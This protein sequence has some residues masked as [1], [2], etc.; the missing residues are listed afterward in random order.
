MERIRAGFCVV[1]NPFNPKQVSRVSLVPDDVDAIVF[2]TRNLRPLIPHLRELD[3][4]GY[5][6][7]FLYTITGYPRVL[8]PNTPDTSKAVATF[9]EL[10]G[11]VGRERVIWRYDPILISNLTPVSY[12]MENFGGLV[13]ELRTS[14]ERVIVSLVD[15]Y[16][17]SRKRLASIGA[18]P[19]EIGPENLEFGKLFESMASQAHA[20]GLEITSC[21]E[22]IDL[23]PYG[24]HPGK[25]IDSAHIRRVLGIDVSHEKDKNQRKTC[26][27]VKSKD[28]G[29]Y[30]TCTH[31][32]VYCYANTN[33]QKAAVNQASH[34]NEGE[35]LK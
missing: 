5:K 7:Y 35:S 16:R 20:A 24:I 33:H 30:D 10:A 19:M 22:D 32:C 4:M 8:E 2:W 6:Y 23:T 12:H 29:Q 31:G 27:C 26:G 11:I 18:S 14:T 1:S 15:D 17:H 34:N 28:I 3:G 21:A 9:Q 13:S 25:C